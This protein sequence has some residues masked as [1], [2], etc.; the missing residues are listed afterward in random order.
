VEPGPR[1][2]KGERTRSRLLEA[3]KA[4][5]ERDGFQQARIADISAEAGVSHGLFYHYFR[6]KEEL[7]RVIADD[8]ETRL[9]AIDYADSDASPVDQLDRIRVANRSYVRTYKREAKIMRVIEEVSRYD[10]DVRRAR[11]RR[12]DFLAARL[13]A[14]IVRMQERGVADPRIDGRY[15][16]MALGGMVARF[17]EQMFI[18]GGRFDEDLAVEQLT[19]L[20][21][22]ALGLDPAK[23]V[24]KPRSQRTPKK[25]AVAAKRG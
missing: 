18:G 15:A 21:A 4:V 19:L 9:L 2:P 24:G 1:S 20:W 10:D 25:A 3:G 11:V 12:D 16:A 14:S 17:A 13:E 6:S 8:V 7:F 22:N 5:F 23:P